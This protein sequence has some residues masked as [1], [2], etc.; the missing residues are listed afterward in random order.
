M[1]S[2]VRCWLCRRRRCVVWVSTVV[3]LCGRNLV[4]DKL[5][6]L[7]FTGSVASAESRH[8][9][10]ENFEFAL[11]RDGCNRCR[12]QRSLHLFRCGG[13]ILLPCRRGQRH[14][15]VDVAAVDATA[16]AFCRLFRHLRSARELL[17]YDAR[18]AASC[19]RRHRLDGRSSR[20]SLNHSSPSL[21]VATQP[22]MSL[23]TLGSVGWRLVRP[24]GPGTAREVV[25]FFVAVVSSG[26]PRVRSRW[27]C[28]TVALQEFC[29]TRPGTCGKRWKLG[30]SM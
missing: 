8:D 20:R 6:V 17:H 23:P 24:V 10:L 3:V 14:C 9:N 2:E 25:P 28:R 16:T 27:P 5:V 1:S 18:Y 11:A 4:L 22:G 19:S 29:G 12:H 21:F 30:G 7:H 26:A 15:G 13:L